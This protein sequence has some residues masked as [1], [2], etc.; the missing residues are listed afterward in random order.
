MNLQFSFEES[1]VV[2]EQKELVGEKKKIHERA[3]F[4]AQRYLVAEADLL[5]SI[6][7]ADR[8]R[9]YEDFGLAYLTPYCVKYLGLSEDVAANFVRVARKTYEVPELK[10][11][12]D[13]GK[14]SVTKAKTIVS[15]INADNQ[16]NWIEKAESFSKSQLEKAVAFESPKPQRP[17][18]AKF[19]GPNRVRYEYDLTEEESALFKR[20]QDTLCQKKGRPMS[21]SETQV[22]L[23]KCFLDKHDP[24]RKAQRNAHK[25]QDPSRDRSEKKASIS[26]ST[27][28]PAAEIHIVNLRDQGQ[29]QA[30]LPDG[31]K[32]GETKWI[33]F[34]HVIPK[35]K[36]GKDKAENL[37]TLCS[38]HHRIWHAR[39]GEI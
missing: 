5:E 2:F 25:S 11:A 6:I 8:N 18:K 28:I 1:A 30:R 29:C 9:L 31:S 20:A 3:L 10:A 13:E 19:E 16:K 39:A 23:L 7:E 14:L 37:V 15:V 33:H 32:C 27:S 34:H 17:E 38:A 35:A 4:R 36:G 24:L 26:K 22:E 12:I 21:L